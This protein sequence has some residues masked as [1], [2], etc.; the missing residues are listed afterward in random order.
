MQL[1]LTASSD[2]GLKKHDLKRRKTKNIA[3]QNVNRHKVGKGP[4]LNVIQSL[5]YA[6]KKKPKKRNT[7]QTRHGVFFLKKD[8][9][10]IN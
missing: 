2:E 5:C 8:N 3:L 7:R 10:T 6:L 1:F 9:S 4:N